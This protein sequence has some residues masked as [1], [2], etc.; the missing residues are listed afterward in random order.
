MSNPLKHH[1]S[2]SFIV[3]Y[4]LPIVHCSLCIALSAFANNVGFYRVE[5]EASGAWHLIDP[6]GEPTVWLGVDHVKFDGFRCEADGN[7]KHYREANERQF[8]SREAWATNTAERLR[9]WGFNGLGAGCDNALFKGSGL[10]RCVFLAL[11]DSA[12]GEKD[13]EEH[14]LSDNLHTPGTAF[15]NV[16]NPDFAEHC[17]REAA[18]ACAPNRDDPEILGYFI[19]NELA[20]E[21]RRGGPSG[22]WGLFDNA[23]RK[24]AGNS[25]R[26]ALEEFLAEC[27]LKVGDDIPV[28]VRMAFVEFVAERY[29]EI[30]TAAIRRHDPNHLVLGC[31]FAGTVYPDE[32]FRAAGKYCDIVSINGYAVPVPD[33][34]EMLLSFRDRYYPIAETLSKLGELSGRPIMLTEWSFP[35]FDSGLPCL[36]GVGKRFDTQAERAWASALYAR[37]VLSCPWVVGY[38][39][40]MWVDMPAKGISYR[41][42]EDSNYGLVREDGREYSELTQAFADIQRRDGLGFDEWRASIARR[43]PLAPPPWT[44]FLTADRL[45]A[46]YL[47]VVPGRLPAPSFSRDGDGWRVS[48]ADGLELRG[49]F[50]SVGVSPA[51][52]AGVEHIV[53]HGFDYGTLSAEIRAHVAPS[54]ENPEGGETGTHRVAQVEDVGW[55]ETPEGRGVLSLACDLGVA[56][57][58]LDITV[59]PGSACLHIDVRRVENTGAVPIVVDEIALLPDAPFPEA[60]VPPKAPRPGFVHRPHVTRAWI[61]RATGRTLGAIS[62]SPFIGVMDFEAAKDGSARRSAV[63]FALSGRAILGARLLVLAP[64]EV[65]T[66]PAPLHALLRPGEGGEGDWDA[67]SRKRPCF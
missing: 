66:P 10:G 16:F 46:E 58:A 1:H 50:R 4:A 52:V 6:A 28:S 49:K 26:I 18:K 12:T 54:P 33:R 55:R 42:P 48:N 43:G 5:R 34:N 35:A 23:A 36:R 32:V 2:A 22:A 19:D 9:S 20:W 14:W 65:W 13:D 39:Y 59:A 44:P 61:D 45:D 31:R 30:T 7:R 64:G 15:P 37:S 47:Q 38:D 67:F 41:F 51:A 63:R 53:S 21:A 27:G 57:M 17:D 11:G 60:T 29:F 62:D 25:A 56:R 40:F 3:H 8:A 24:P